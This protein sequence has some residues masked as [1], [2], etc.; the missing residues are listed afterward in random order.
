MIS[1]KRA[2]RIVLQGE[3]STTIFYSK[4]KILFQNWDKKYFGAAQFGKIFIYTLK[5]RNQ[6]KLTKSAAIYIK[7]QQY[8]ICEFSS[9]FTLHPRY[10]QMNSQNFYSKFRECNV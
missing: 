7:H 2:I 1:S 6:Q 10:T 3:Q 9:V 4:L 5:H 8:I